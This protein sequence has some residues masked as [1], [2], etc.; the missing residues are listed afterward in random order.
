MKRTLSIAGSMLM[1]LVLLAPVDAAAAQM[2]TAD[3]QTLSQSMD[4]AELRLSLP[5]PTGQFAVGVRAGSVSDPSRID[6]ATR[7]PRR[8]PIRIWYPAR[9]RAAG[10]PAAYMSPTVQAAAEQVLGLP[11]GLLR[12]D[13]HASVDVP[14]RRHG[15]GVVLAQAGRGSLVA[16]QTAQFVDLA[17]RGYFVVTM[18]HP[19]E[20]F[21]VE[22]PDGTLIFGNPANHSF[23]ARILDAAA[24]LN[25]LG[26]LV[27]EVQPDTPIGMFGHSWGG[28]ATAEFM[29][30]DPR[31]LAGV[32]LDGSALGDV[33]TAGLDRPFGLMLSRLH[34]PENVPETFEFISNLRG[35]HPIERLDILHAGYTD[36]VVFNPELAR[37]DPALGAL[38]EQVFP[39]GTV[40]SLRAGRRAVT[41][42]RQF[43]ATFMECFL[44][45]GRL[46]IGRCAA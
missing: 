31:V 12:V 3:R 28:A 19:H 32:N 11:N 43:L 42:Q 44:V 40:D 35:P 20:S 33:V 15:R 9:H 38:L 23:E 7:K 2:P 24:V 26:R 25:D 14:A 18:D 4:L 6:E 34:T 13:T 46:V 8:I 27:P 39:T 5:S 17:S 36:F 16:F 37:V 45:K 10:P 22:E 21:V 30:R 29:L 41:A 1:S